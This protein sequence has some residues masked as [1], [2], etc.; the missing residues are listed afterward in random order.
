MI[1]TRA[2]LFGDN[3]YCTSGLNISQR[4]LDNNVTFVGTGNGTQC[5]QLIQQVMDFAKNSDPSVPP[6]AGKF[7]VSEYTLTFYVCFMIIFC[8][9][10]HARHSVHSTKLLMFSTLQISIRHQSTNLKIL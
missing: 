8:L 6:A 3:H 4:N 5:R 10:C 2:D 7:T 9:Y 1:I